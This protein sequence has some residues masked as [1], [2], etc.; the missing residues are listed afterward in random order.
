MDKAMEEGGASHRS[1]GTR[2]GKDL[3]SLESLLKQRK[4]SLPDYL[5]ETKTMVRAEEDPEEDPKEDLK[6]DHK[7][8]LNQGNRLSKAPHVNLFQSRCAQHR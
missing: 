7:E 4:I 3:Q 6:E 8:S 5:E 2:G 1:K